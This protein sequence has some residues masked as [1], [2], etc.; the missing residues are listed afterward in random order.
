MNFSIENLKVKKAIEDIECTMFAKLVDNK[1]YSIQYN[2][3]LEPNKTYGNNNMELS[4]SFVEYVP[5]KFRCVTNSLFISNRVDTDGFYFHFDVPYKELVLTTC[6]IP[7][8]TCYLENEFEY[9]STKIKIGT[10]V[11]K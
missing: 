6:L 5:N 11:I 8:G 10:E 4:I 2:I 7:K 3:L 9:L 1:L